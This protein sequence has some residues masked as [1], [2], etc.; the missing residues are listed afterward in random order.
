[1]VVV[2][3]WVVWVHRSNRVYRIVRW[4]NWIDVRHNG[5]SWMMNVVM[6][7]WTGTNLDW[8]ASRVIIFHNYMQDPDIA[9]DANELRL[10]QS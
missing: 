6:H 7:R 2:V 1:M 9:L 3:V 5:N 8:W 10:V 4:L